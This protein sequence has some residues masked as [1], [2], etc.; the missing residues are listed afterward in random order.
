MN[1]LICDKLKEIIKLQDIIKKG[2]LNFKSKQGKNCNF[3]KYSLPIVIFSGIH[4][5]TLSTEK[6]NNKQDNFANELKNFKKG[7]KTH[8][9]FILK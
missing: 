9:K 2:D 6:T 1:F 8:K 5:G 3:C 4:E 7:T